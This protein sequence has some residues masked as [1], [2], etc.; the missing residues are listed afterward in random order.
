[1]K[2]WTTTFATSL[3]L[4]GAALASD[5]NSPAATNTPTTAATPQPAPPIANPSST[6]VEALIQI[7]QKKYVNPA[8]VAEAEMNKAAVQGIVTALG[9]GAELIVPATTVA[10]TN[11]PPA[12][13]TETIA[14]MMG[15]V[16][17]KTI[18]AATIKQLD[19]ALTKFDKE[20]I[21]SL[22]IDLRFTKGGTFADAAELVSHFL[23]KDKPLFT[24]REAQGSTD[25]TFVTTQPSAFIDWKLALVVNGETE[26]AAEAAAAALREQARALVVGTNSAGKAVVWSEETLPS[27]TKV[28][29]A[30]G[31]AVTA[32]GTDLFPKG[33]IPDVP[34]DS[35]AEVDRKLLFELSA[36]K[37]LRQFVEAAQ[38]EKRLNE[39]TLVKMLGKGGTNE[40]S[41]A[42]D[43][44]SKK[45]G[46]SKAV[47]GEKDDKKEKKPDQ[48]MDTTLQRAV[49]I[50]KGI[51][52]L[53]LD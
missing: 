35:L 40:P 44:P 22:V 38:T 50:L 34:T 4:C 27:G 23:L 5:T 13:R 53:H 2:T 7:L 17:L 29:I 31:K 42:A 41:G 19:E 33:V 24:I 3:C 28:R 9:S 14:P 48:P 36:G 8:Q 15:Y 10:S 43:E 20:K 45:E 47:K 37:P 46:H 51:R 39:A 25:K 21:D 26:G 18:D 32:K 12:L 52:I 11:Q 49:D 1:M 30:T 16:W 6:D